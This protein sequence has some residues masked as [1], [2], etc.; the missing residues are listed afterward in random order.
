MLKTNGQPHK[1]EIWDKHLSLFETRI[2]IIFPSNLLLIG[3][4]V[5]LVLLNI[6]GYPRQVSNA[7]YWLFWLQFSIA[8]LFALLDKKLRKS[9]RRNPQAKRRLVVGTLCHDLLIF[10]Y[11][12]LV[13][14]LTVL[15]FLGKASQKA[16]LALLFI[17]FIYAYLFAL[18]PAAAESSRKL[19]NFVNSK[20][21][22]FFFTVVMIFIA[23]YIL[24]VYGPIH[25]ELIM[26]FVFATLPALI[27]YMLGGGFR[28]FVILYTTVDEVAAPDS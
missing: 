18:K 6:D 27:T 24:L 7:V 1:K 11:M 23:A 8:V 2:S 3:F 5:A 22:R 15:F 12:D 26:I 13:I 16:F 9:V 10:T 4:P 21:T 17:L 14:T 25:T 20:V 19:S 28:R